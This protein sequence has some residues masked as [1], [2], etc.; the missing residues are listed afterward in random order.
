M[1]PGLQHQVVPPF[2]IS[3]IITVL[4]ATQYTNTFNSVG[5]Y[6]NYV[7]EVKSHYRTIRVVLVQCSDLPLTIKATYGVGFLADTVTAS[8]KT[9]AEHRWGE[10]GHCR[11]VKSR[12]HCKMS[13]GL[14]GIRVSCRFCSD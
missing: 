13:V 2:W 11:K 6:R 7:M 12:L 8:R 10:K 4:L 1:E 5:T 3:S 14:M 9:V